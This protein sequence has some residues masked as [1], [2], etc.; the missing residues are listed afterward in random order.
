MSIEKVIFNNLINNDE[1]ARKVIP[2]LKRD[3]FDN[4]VDQ[5]IYE[6]IDNYVIEYNAFPTKSILT[7]ELGNV[8]GI[9]EKLYNDCE[10][11][12]LSI[13]DQSNDISNQDWLLDQTERFCQDKA[14][15][16]AIS[17]SLLIMEKDDSGISKGNIPQL[18]TDALAVSFETAIGHDFLVDAEE[19]YN[20]YHL[21]EERIEFDLDFLNKITR[22]GLPRKSLT[23][24]LAETGGGKSLAM[25]HMA[26][27]NM[28]MGYNVLYITMEMAEEK[29]AERID[30]NLLDI[31]ID[32]LPDLTRDRY[33]SKMQTLRDRTLGKLI[34]KEYPTSCAGANNFRHLLRELKIKKNFVPDVIYIDYIN[35]CSS[36]RYKA[37]TNANS[38][39][40]VK[41]IAEE[42]RGLAVEQNVAMVTATQVTR[43][44]FNNSELDITD[45]SESIGL[46]AT[47]DLFLAII[48]TGDLKQ[49]NRIMMKQLKNRYSDPERFKKF[50]LGID[51]PYMRLYDVPQFEQDEIIDES[52]P[53]QEQSAAPPIY[54]DDNVGGGINK[55]IFDKFN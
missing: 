12:I 9:T 6:L 28:K 20:F 19:R 16:N 15:F 8:K 43:S 36:S 39:T 42:L 26:A 31:Q 32:Q 1:Y 53:K 24:L 18:L 4:P 5:T 46:P 13:P 27:A 23:C 50:L 41:S 11:L 40:I 10:E 47:L 30:A 34:I 51:K 7:I 14:I 49:K 52:M 38:Y 21:K 48:A 2:F 22:G 37:G 25:C 55:N 44:G 45:V 33:L 35:I 29:I 17:E 3:Y 54:Y